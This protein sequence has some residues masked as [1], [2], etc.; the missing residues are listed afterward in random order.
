MASQSKNQRQLI[1]TIAF[2]AIMTHFL[3]L[4]QPGLAATSSGQQQTENAAASTQ[5]LWSYQ[6]KPTNYVG[7]G[8][9]GGQN[10]PYSAGHSSIFDAFTGLSQRQG[11]L[12]GNSPLLSILP[13][14]LI[15]AGGLLLLL[16]MLT[17]M[18]ASPFGGG[19]FGAGGYQNYGYPQLG[20]NKRR[21]LDQMNAGGS[22]GILELIEHVSSTIEDLSRKYSGGNAQQQQASGATAATGQQQAAAAATTSHTLNK[23]SKAL[24]AGQAAPT[25]PNHQQASLESPQIHPS[26]HKLDDGETRN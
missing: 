6:V 12:T 4:L 9:A 3:A 1:G 25:P 11:A 14:I 17:M 8:Q 18:M 2:I 20:L 23:R 24:N 19:P 5:P 15:A 22:R 26:N 16:P 7:S 10:A 21:S 13:I